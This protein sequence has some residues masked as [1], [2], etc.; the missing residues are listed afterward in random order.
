MAPVIL[1]HGFAQTPAS[2]NAVAAALQERGHRVCAVDLLGSIR[3]G[4]GGA[5]CERASMAAVCAHLAS[6]VR[7]IAAGEDAPLLVGY[8][9]GGRLAAETLVRYPDLPLEALVLEGAGLGP[10][11]EEARASLARRNGEWGVRLRAEGV[12]AFMDWWETLPLFATQR[13]LPAAVRAAVRAERTAND[14]ETLARVLEA[15]GA[16]HQAAESDTLAALARAH[17]A[18][19]S[20]LYV[21]GERDAK[22]CAVAD[23]VRA[24]GL[25]ATTVPNAGHNVHLERPDAFCAALA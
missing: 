9:M 25:R 21:A 2:W 13:D 4:F 7:H 20:V 18:G 10:A 22:Y 15:W 5:P 24:A 12:E 14:A 16:Q 11:N 1:L 23:R 3:P 17:A 19:T 8:S 6:L